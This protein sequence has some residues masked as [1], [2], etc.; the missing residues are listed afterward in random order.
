[1]SPRLAFAA[2][3]CGVVGL[4]TGAAV[5]G[6]EPFLKAGD[7]VALVGGEDMVSASEYGYLELLLQRALPDFH[8]KVRSLAWEGDTV[9][10][11][12]RDL[13]YPTLEQ[14]LDQIGATVVICQFGQMESLAGKEKLPD[15][16][17]AYEELI[18][19]VSGGGNRRFILIRPGYFEKGEPPYVRPP[20]LY[21]DRTFPIAK[22]NLVL[23]A[24]RAAI[25]TIAETHHY[26]VVL[27]QLS[28]EELRETGYPDAIEGK[29]WPTMMNTRDGV[30]RNGN[31]YVLLQQHLQ[32]TLP[33]LRHANS[34]QT[35]I[36]S[37]EVT[38]PPEY[39]PL[40]QLI[41]QK[42]RLWYHYYRPSN[43]AFLAGDRTHQP[44]SRDY[45]DPT[46]RWF[47]A[48]MEQWLPLIGAKEKEIWAAA[49]VL[50]P[51]EAAK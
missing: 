39:E 23:D 25:R 26:P 32:A 2:L 51:E 7:V 27:G 11:Q 10:E 30:H 37:G 14:Q 1:M 48:E 19:R 49:A 28:G 15:F 42:N 22:P 6:K 46:K 45:L 20:N 17:A 35:F 4:W 43:W 5:R 47:P 16:I 41:I 38:K 13:N 34:N 21:P 9:F 31:G 33:E 24:Y 50:H 8:L 12:R 3:V 44:S 29:E 36:S 18:T 40:R